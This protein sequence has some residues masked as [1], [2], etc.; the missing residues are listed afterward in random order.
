[1]MTADSIL[2]L[3]D[4][5]IEG[6]TAFESLSGTDIVCNTIDVGTIAVGIGEDQIGITLDGNLFVKNDAG[7]A[8]VAIVGGASEGSIYLQCDSTVAGTGSVIR[9]RDTHSG[10]PVYDALIF[11]VDAGAL[12]VNVGDDG[13][14][15]ATSATL[16]VFGPFFAD[17]NSSTLC[18]DATNHRVGI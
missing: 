13:S 12:E 4:L 18:V 5:T 14:I 6:F 2:C 17:K 7:T 3:G 8:S 16:N 9:V 1:A 15:V 11:N 10:G